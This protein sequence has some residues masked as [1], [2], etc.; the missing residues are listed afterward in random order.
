MSAVVFWVGMLTGSE[1]EYITSNFRVVKDEHL[2]T[3]G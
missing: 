1:E 3:K 2:E